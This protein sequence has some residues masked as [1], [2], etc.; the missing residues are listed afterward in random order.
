MRRT[1]VLLALIAVAVFGAGAVP[2]AAIAGGKPTPLA[3]TTGGKPMPLLSAS[4]VDLTAP[5]SASVVGCTYSGASAVV[6]T[7]ANFSQRIAWRNCGVING[8]GGVYAEMTFV[9]TAA[10]ANSHVTGCSM[11]IA[12]VRESDGSSTD[13]P[14]DCTFEAH[15]IHGTWTLASDA[16]WVIH[17]TGAYH[18][19]GWFNIKT[20]C[21]YYNTYA[22]AARIG[23]R[24]G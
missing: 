23:F 17:H 11:Q 6:A 22:Q 24:A 10:F 2:S 21:C 3:V 16:T 8:E 15:N 12:L 7:K 13:M 18:F 19:T 4:I 20:G 14:T 5:T 1:T 9:P